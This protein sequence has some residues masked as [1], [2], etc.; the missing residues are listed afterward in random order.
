M[1]PISKTDLDQISMTI[2]SAM[3]Q[4]FAQLTAALSQPRAATAQAKTSYR[5]SGFLPK[6]LR[7][8]LPISPIR[9]GRSLLPSLDGASRSRL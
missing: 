6:G 4:G 7:P 3:S 5:Y 1:S 9:T 2:A 8:L